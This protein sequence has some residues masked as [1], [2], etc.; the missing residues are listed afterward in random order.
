[1]CRMFLKFELFD[2]TIFIPFFNLLAIAD[3]GWMPNTPK[4]HTVDQLRYA[5]SE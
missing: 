5:K 4:P 2:L 3:D 1:M